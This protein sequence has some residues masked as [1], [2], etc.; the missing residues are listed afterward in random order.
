MYG[1]SHQHCQDAPRQCNITAVVTPPSMAAPSCNSITI[2]T[3]I[4]SCDAKLH[5]TLHTSEGE[6]EGCC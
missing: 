3:F 1:R 2:V 4:A 6:I 5:P